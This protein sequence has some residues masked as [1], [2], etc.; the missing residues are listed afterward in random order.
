MATLHIEV[1]ILRKKQRVCRILKHS[2]RDAGIQHGGQ[3][4]RYLVQDG[5]GVDGGTWTTGCCR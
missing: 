5:L 1:R 3:I 4:G 2:L